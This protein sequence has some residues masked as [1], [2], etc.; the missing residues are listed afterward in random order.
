MK[1]EPSMT[2]DTDD[3]RAQFDAKLDALFDFV[4]EEE[5][6]DDDSDD[7]DDSDDSDDGYASDLEVLG[8]VAAEPGTKAHVQVRP[9]RLD[10]EQFA[11]VDGLL[12]PWIEKFGYSTRVQEIRNRQA[13]LQYSQDPQKSLNYLIEQLNLHFNHQRQIPPAEQNLANSLDQSLFAPDALLAQALQQFDNTQGIETAGLH[14]LADKF[15]QLSR[16]QRRHLL[17]VAVNQV[18]AASLLGV[19]DG[20]VQLH[21][22]TF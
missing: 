16:T 7:L 5:E 22:R 12:K 3:R 21:I 4:P 10:A 20:Q 6:F 14:L 11:Q 9:H 2:G 17:A 19:G 15:P 18:A 1:I 8:T 13:L